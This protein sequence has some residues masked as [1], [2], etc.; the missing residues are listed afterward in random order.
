MAQVKLSD[1]FNERPI[2][3]RD[4]AKRLLGNDAL[5]DHDYEE[6]T[7][8]CLQEVENLCE[9]TEYTLPENAFD[10]INAYKLKLVSI[11]DVQGINALAPKVPLQFG[12]GNLAVVYGQNGAGKSGYVRILKHACG[13]RH[14]GNLLP[15]AYSTE[16]VQQQC[17]I[18][19]EKNDVAIHQEWVA[20]SGFLPDLK[21][22]DIFDA[23]CGKIY[24]VAE[25]EVTYEPPVLSFFSELISVSEEISSQLDAEI[26]KLPSK[27]PNL[28]PEYS[29]T[30]VGQWY[31]KLSIKTKK[32]D[33][34]KYYSWADEDEQKTIE[35]QKRLAEKAPAEKAEQIRKQQQHIRSLI[36]NTEKYVGQLSDEN[37][38]RIISA[39]A[40]VVL[41]QE[42]AKAA[43]NKVFSGAPLAGVG[44]NVWAQLWEHARKYSQE[45]AYVGCDFPY[46]D[47]ESHCVLCHQPLSEEAKARMISFEEFVKGT[48]QKEA[49]TAQENF[50]KAL[51]SISEIPTIE[52][53]KTKADAAG[54]DQGK[55]PFP[56]NEVYSA[57]QKRK[58]LLNKVE[59]FKDL[60]T[61]PQCKVWIAEAE[62]QI[63]ASEKIAKQYDEDS[64]TDNRSDLKAELAEL[65]ARKWSSQ[66]RKSI[67]DELERLKAIHK[68]QAAKKQTN[69][70]S[71]STKKGELAETLITEAFVERFNRELE[72]L[73]ANHIEIELIKSK[74]KKGKVLHRL[75]LLDSN[76][77][78]PEDVLSEGEHRIV[79]LAAFLA[80]VTGKKQPAPF[81]FDDPISSLD[82]P[83][84]EAVVQRL[85][86]LSQDRQVIVLTHRLSLLGLVQDY[87]KKAGVKPEVVCIR[88]EDWGTGEPGGT[89]LFAKKPEKALKTLLDRLPKARKLLD[90]HGQ[91]VY[92]PQA[93]ALCS[94]FR[95]L[96]ERMV[97]CNLLADVVQRY[98]RAINTMGKI[99]NLAKIN[100]SDCKFIDD[101]MTK[102]SRYEHAQPI[103]APVS[104]PSPDSL[105]NDFK[106]LQVWHDEFKNR[107]TS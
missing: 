24:V 52:N 106:A 89:P 31:G 92:D 5:N 42:V 9:S 100:K 90:E 80:D 48:A 65:L 103:E 82:Q 74:V 1:W 51:K 76:I 44:S 4:A 39:K 54:L 40:K 95:I 99:D 107:P 81:V 30:S 37:C 88:K 15:N 61:L 33:V 62:K 35:L 10:N 53:L 94:D 71:L 63:S 73:G 7:T 38:R 41:L 23:S 84:E 75:R 60:P 22:V 50:D 19:Y 49:D 104:M 17:S 14:P 27:K 93:K 85:V 20:S 2:W 21:S 67:Y 86:A 105:E 25:N 16:S 98:R 70:R 3:L 66:Q 72:S 12:K 32:E 26:G 34:K 101:L 47:A 28:P 55:E 78:C 46:V 64:G 102:Y 96:V 57:L 29:N 58:E 87:A 43:A 59:S 45:Q 91:E 83:F 79:A 69:T 13:A 36:K 8:L 18:D 97:E 56:L 77:D 6:L 11:S 68:L